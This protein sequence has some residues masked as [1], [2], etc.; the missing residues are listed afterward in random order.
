[1]IP[2]ICDFIPYIHHYHMEVSRNRESPVVTMA[3]SMLKWSSMTWMIW[4]ETPPIFFRQFQFKFLFHKL[5]RN[6]LETSRKLPFRSHFWGNE[7]R[8]NSGFHHEPRE[9][10]PARAYQCYDPWTRWLRSTS[11]IAVEEL[12][13][14]KRGAGRK[15]YWNNKNNNINI[16]IFIYTITIIILIY[17]YMCSMG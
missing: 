8:R 12:E 13:R 4:V 11:Q 3:V 17:I 15:W 6:F 10:T 2:V 7:P 9:R 5:F 16:G 14:P 1:M